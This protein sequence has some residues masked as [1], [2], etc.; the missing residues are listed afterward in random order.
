[1]LGLVR[2]HVGEGG[3]RLLRADDDDVLRDAASDVAVQIG[4]DRSQVITRELVDVPLEAGLRPASLVVRP[5][6]S[7]ERS[8]SGSSRPFTSSKR[9]PRSR[10]I[11]ATIPF[12]AAEQ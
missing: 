11:T 7:S 4:R 8:A 9:R 5:G 12:A 1:M 3:A 6:C 2:E 10:T